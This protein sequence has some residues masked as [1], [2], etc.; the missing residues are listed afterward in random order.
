[1]FSKFAHALRAPVPLRAQ[2]GPL[3]CSL[4]RALCTTVGQPKLASRTD[5]LC[6]PTIAETTI[7]DSRA[8]ITATI[9]AAPTWPH[10]SRQHAVTTAAHADHGRADHRHRP[11]RCRACLVIAW[12]QS[13]CGPSACVAERACG[14]ARLGLSAHTVGQPKL[15]SRTDL[16]CA[17]TCAEGCHVALS[18]CPVTLCCLPHWSA[19]CPT[20][21]HLCALQ[22]QAVAQA[23]SAGNSS[24]TSSTSTGNGGNSIRAL[25]ERYLSAI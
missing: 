25:S 20:P 13:M 8:T 3:P 19:A 5:L 6:A 1:M 21:P 9:I 12:G 11:D 17:W 16:L 15:A 14:C 2:P 10:R 24:A 22:A 23:N 18:R 4:T 7:A